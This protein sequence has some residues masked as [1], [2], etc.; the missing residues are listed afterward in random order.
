MTTSKPFYHPSRVSGLSS[1]RF[2]IIYLDTSTDPPTVV[3]SSATSEDLVSE[4]GAGWYR[5][6]GLPNATGPRS[7][8]VYDTGAALTV[9]E[10]YGA[11]IMAP[12]TYML[13]HHEEWSGI[14]SMVSGLVALFTSAGGNTPITIILN[15]SVTGLPIVGASISIW[16]QDLSSCLVPMLTTSVSG[17]VVTALP[18]GTYS[19]F[20]FKPFAIF[21]NLPYTLT[22]VS[23]PAIT[24]TY[25]GQD[26]VAPVTPTINKVTLY[27]F[28]LAPSGVPLSGVEV[29][30]R[31]AST[32]SM[33]QTAGFARAAVSVLTDSTGY[34]EVILPGGTKVSVECE[35]V[36]YSRQG[37]LRPSGTQDWQSFSVA[38]IPQG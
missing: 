33:V 16:T 17:K 5:I 2:N 24:V 18:A 11:I 29:K 38:T 7:L 1:S 19:V 30:V 27:G 8:I 21:G 26:G 9:V 31:M 37:V 23:G 6:T 4:I 22:V 10:N 20:V 28:V 36:G 15:D 35:T 14:D 13:L 12:G 32:P 34:F 25:T 3:L